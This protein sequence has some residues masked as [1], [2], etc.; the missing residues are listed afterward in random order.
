MFDKTVTIKQA[1]E[2]T[3]IHEQWLLDHVTARSD[4]IVLRDVLEAAKDYQRDESD[5][6]ARMARMR[7]E[8]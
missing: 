6:H 7:Y 5:E 1:A 3:G 8:K 4:G 2:L